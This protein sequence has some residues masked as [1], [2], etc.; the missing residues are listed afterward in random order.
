MRIFRFNCA[1]DGFLNG[2]AFTGSAVQKKFFLIGVCFMLS[3]L[4]KCDLVSFVDFSQKNQVESPASSI[5][6]SANRGV[7]D[8]SG[9]LPSAVSDNCILID[10]LTFSSKS[11][12]FDSMVSLLGLTHVKWSRGKGSRLHYENVMQFSGISIHYT[13]CDSTKF[14]RGA[15]CEMSGQ[16]CRAFETYSDIDFVRLF[17][18]LYSER[19]NKP[20]IYNPAT[21]E[22][23]YDN[24]LDISITRLD[25]AFDDHTGVI[26]L[27][28]WAE[29]AR[30]LCFTSRCSALQ[31]TESFEKL[32]PAFCGLSICHGSRS[33]NVFIRIYDK[34]IERHAF[35]LDHW[36]RFE[37]Q[38]RADAA[39]GFVEN[40]CS[41]I[42]SEFRLGEFFTGIV[43]HYLE[44]KCPCDDLNKSRWCPAPF[45]RR[46]LGDVSE[47]S[48]ITKKTLDYNL[49][50][51]QRY[52]FQQ[53]HNHTKSL[54]EM[55]GA[56]DYLL[57]LNQFSDTIPE[58]YKGV[59]AALDHGD[60]I[61]KYLSMHESDSEYL[62]R[63]R[64]SIDSKISD[65]QS[66]PA[67]LG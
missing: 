24:V 12:D 27:D 59:A 17:Q 44:Y 23:G 30:R 64:D 63:C 61:L 66:V 18:F 29:F 62:R 9:G 32:D 16:G 67:E 15:C 35:D 13:S 41:E 19:Y 31:I 21:K 22:L 47:L 48:T 45:W 58:K 65:L 6:P 60:E 1:K 25:L 8:T 46:F 39:N 37:I 54:I 14:N 53:N 20:W 51:M 55:V 43:K 11:Y 38:L 28:V 7:M 52:A 57:Q 5:P 56:A 33:S 3:D 42:G 10:W 4:T 26:Q 2:R 50:R 49:D 36:V 40:F 34:R